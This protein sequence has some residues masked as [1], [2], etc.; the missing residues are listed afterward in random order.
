METEA[1]FEGYV[2]E[3]EGRIDWALTHPGMSEW[4]KQALRGARARDPTD[5]LNDLEMLNHLLQK[6]AEMQI[7][8][9]SR[10]RDSTRRQATTGE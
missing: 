10:F 6:R 3:A 1:M 4:L 9:L 7:Q 5:I 2:K 8:T